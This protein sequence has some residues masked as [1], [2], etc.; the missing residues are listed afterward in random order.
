MS[1]ASNP[2]IPAV[3]LVSRFDPGPRFEVLMLEQ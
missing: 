1:V 3:V 2:D